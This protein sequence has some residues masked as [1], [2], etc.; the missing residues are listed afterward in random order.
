MFNTFLNIQ[1]TLKLNSVRAYQ[2]HICM[3]ILTLLIVS[4]TIPD[5]LEREK[6]KHFNII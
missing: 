2:A 6:T 1:Q 3:S 5:L 4:M